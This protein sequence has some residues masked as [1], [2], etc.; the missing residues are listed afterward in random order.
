MK[1]IKNYTRPLWFW[2]NKPTKEGLTEIME[3]CKNKDKYA[4]FGILAFD[5][6]G[7]EYL[8]EEYLD[9][10]GHVLKEA[11]KLNLKICLYDEWWFPSGYA[12]GILKKK[13]PEALAKRLDLE[14][15]SFDGKSIKVKLPTDGKIMAVVALKDTVRIDLAPFV[16]DGVLEYTADD[17]GFKALCFILRNADWDH[18]DF[19]SQDAVAKFIECTHEV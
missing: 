15:F 5:K 2:N 4:G 17:N 3:N 16:E 19:L 18:V 11:K 8:G 7:L 12:G 6:C 14:E 13:H 10:Y 1:E 9:L